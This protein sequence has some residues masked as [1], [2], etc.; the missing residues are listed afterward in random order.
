V[1]AVEFA[2]TSIANDLRAMREAAGLTQVELAKK[3]K[4][5]QAFV[6]GAE[7]GSSRVGERYVLAVMAACGL[8]EDW[9][10]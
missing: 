6:S 10:G 3:L 7:S 8:P 5:S 2:R 1:D 9:K 4:K